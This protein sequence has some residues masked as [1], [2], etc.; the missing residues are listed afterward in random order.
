[1]QIRANIHEKYNETELHV[2]KDR[3]DDEVRRLM[4]ELHAMYD[5]AIN[6]TDEVGN[7]CV[8]RPAEIITFYAEKQRVIALDASKKYTIPKTLVELE[9]ELHDYGFFRI[10][11]SELVNLHRIRSLDLSVTGTIRVIMK[12]GYETYASRRNVSRLKEQLAGKKIGG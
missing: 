10:S 12:N 1:M 7:R 2:C 6:G 5:P 8:I 11:K 3:M 9:Q 4:D